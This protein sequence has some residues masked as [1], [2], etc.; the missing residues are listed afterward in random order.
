V[1]LLYR[2]LRRT[3]LTVIDYGGEVA[4]NAGRMSKCYLLQ[5]PLSGSYTLQCAERPLLVNARSAHIVYP[6]M[7]LHM[8][9]SSDCRILVFR[10]EE[11]TLGV[12]RG[13]LCQRLR[14]SSHGELLAFDSEPNRS[15]G[16][17][18][19]Y[20]M[21]EATGG[22]LFG[23]ASHAAAHAENL[24][25]A[26][27]IETLGCGERQLAMRPAPIYVQRAEQY[28]LEN[29]TENLTVAA[30]ARACATTP[31]TLY[32]GF[33]RTHGMGPFGWARAQRLERAHVDLLSARHGDVRVTDVAMRWGFQHLGRFC[34]AYKSRFGEVP[35]TTLYRDS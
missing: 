7:P 19:E 6:G 29:L 35:T 26:G 10:F 31:R 13:R 14:K 20:V 2:R 18:V 5:V 23:G 21:N 4:I 32:D 1:R 30:V 16:R 28:L 11:A 25:L 8:V 22:K 12:E 9:M 34:Q 27:L 17:I 33:R 3:G 15:L 24:L